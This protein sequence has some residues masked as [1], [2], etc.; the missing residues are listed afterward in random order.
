MLADAEGAEEGLK[1]ELKEDLN[2]EGVED[3]KGLK[4]DELKDVFDGG[5]GIAN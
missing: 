4:D 3:A 5:G 1:E 2:A